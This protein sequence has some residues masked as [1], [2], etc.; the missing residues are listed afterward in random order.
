MKQTTPYYC[1]PACIAFIAVRFCGH[2]EGDMSQ[3]GIAGAIGTTTDG[4]GIKGIKAGLRLLGLQPQPVS[5]KMS[6]QE[7]PTSQCVL[8][9]RT[10]DHWMVGRRR[11]DGK[12]EVFDPE[13]GAESTYEPSQWQKAFFS[14]WDSYAIF[15]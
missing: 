11:F 4:T 5:G 12:W 2:Y 8:W 15:F 1:G 7:A 3:S 10:R 14:H 9:D 13:T 6:F